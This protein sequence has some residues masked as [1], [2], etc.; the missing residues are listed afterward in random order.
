MKKD[1]ILSIMA[2]GVYII[3]GLATFAGAIVIVLLRG[4]DLWGWGD[5]YGIGYLLVFVGLIMSVLGVLVMR[6]VRN[7]FNSIAVSSYKQPG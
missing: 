2:L 6:I 3:G 5:A 7:R 1:L 4:K